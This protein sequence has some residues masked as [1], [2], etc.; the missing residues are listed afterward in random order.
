M[1]RTRLQSLTPEQKLAIVR[2]SDKQP[3]WKQKQLGR[4]A[5]DKFQLPSVPSQPM[6][7]VVL[8]QGGKPVKVRTPAKRPPK[9]KVIK[10]PKVEKAMLQWLQK[11]IDKDEAV[12][13]HS[14]QTQA[15]IIVDRLSATADG[16]VV[17]DAWVD[18][19]MRHHVLNCRF[20]LSDSE[21]GESDKEQE[22]VHVEKKKN[23][24][25]DSR[26]PVPTAPAGKRKRDNR[27]GARQVKARR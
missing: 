4:W 14:V 26:S 9:P 19:F 15:K 11:K 20:G 10:C 5:A 23:V 22:A 17:S 13:V 24:V 6:I 2:Q 16:F 8:R 1:G 25:R 18:S 3:E 27:V 7:S 21:T 12:A